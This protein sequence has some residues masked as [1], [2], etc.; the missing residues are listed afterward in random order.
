MAR[1]IVGVFRRRLD[2]PD[3]HTVFERNTCTSFRSSFYPF[4]FIWN[5][6]PVEHEF[7]RVHCYRASVTLSNCVRNLFHIASHK[8]TA[9][10]RQQS[11]TVILY[12]FGLLVPLMNFQRWWQEFDV[13]RRVWRWRMDTVI[14]RWL[15]QRRWIGWLL[16][17]E[18]CSLR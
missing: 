16:A 13:A 5:V 2:R 7:S 4:C 10:L 9:L 12:F 6:L 1:V 14:R 11:F 15:W 8:Y 17:S 18:R 3:R